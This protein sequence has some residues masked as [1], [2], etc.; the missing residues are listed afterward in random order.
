MAS[1]LARMTFIFGI[2]SP[3]AASFRPGNRVSAGTDDWVPA[4]TVTRRILRNWPFWVT[5]N[6]SPASWTGRLNA[7]RALEYVKASDDNCTHLS[8]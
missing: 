7:P 5:I 1:Q 6:C 8:Q 4:R 3:F 2:V